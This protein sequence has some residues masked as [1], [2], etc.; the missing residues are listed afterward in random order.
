[1]DKKVNVSTNSTV[2]KFS[3]INTQVF[4]N[5]EPPVFVYSAWVSQAAENES[6]VDVY[7]PQLYKNIISMDSASKYF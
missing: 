5:I 6:D 3:S 1:L 4:S 7:G 2:S